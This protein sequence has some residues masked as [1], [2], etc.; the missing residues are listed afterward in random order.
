MERV[1]VPDDFPSILSGTQALNRLQQFAQVTV[2]KEK[3]SSLEE[4]IQRLQGTKVAINIP[5]L[6][7]V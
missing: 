6:F 4:L 1:V 5:G 3:A 2:Y 7:Q